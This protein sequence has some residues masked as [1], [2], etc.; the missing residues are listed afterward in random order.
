MTGLIN[1]LPTT[2]KKLY[3]LAKEGQAET[4][5]DQSALSEPPH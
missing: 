5:R 3:D 1:F 4:G 2:S